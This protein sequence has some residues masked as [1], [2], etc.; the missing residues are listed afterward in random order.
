VPQPHL[1]REFLALLQKHYEDGGGCTH[2]ALGLLLDHVE[3]L[4][5]ELATL[6]VAL[7]LLTGQDRN[8]D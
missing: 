8:G 3:G 5:R 4:E 2:E 7:A 6:T 1:P